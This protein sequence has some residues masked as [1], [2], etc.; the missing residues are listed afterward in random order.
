MTTIESAPSPIF[1]TGLSPFLKWP[2]G[3]SGELAKI[4][5][6][7]PSNASRFIEPFL[8]GG[9]VLLSVVDDIPAFGNDVVPELVGLYQGGA[10]NSQTLRNQLEILVECWRNFNDLES[11]YLRLAAQVVG[12]SWTSLSI[13]DL[14]PVVLNAVRIQDASVSH[15][16]ERRVHRDLPS[17]LARILKLQIQHDRE[18]PIDELANNI[19]ASIRSSY[20]M[21]IRARY[22]AAR[23]SNLWNETRTADFFFLREY[24]YASMFRFNSRDEFNIPYGGISY[25]RKNFKVKVDALFSTQMQARLSNSRFSVGD[26][27][28]LFEDSN[29]KSGDFIFVDPPY[30]SDFTDYD[31]RT[32]DSSDQQ[33][34]ASS[35]SSL[36]ANV[37]VVIGDT[38]L[39]RKLYP[40]TNWNIQSDDMFYKWTVKSRNERSAKHLTITNY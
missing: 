18:L 2:G 30:D 39:I 16:F 19:E 15:D 27:E 37:M 36:N 34:L 21:A 1:R 5:L 8:G 20:Y 7:S 23:V 22:N 4:A 26:F 6:A 31:G 38:P 40:D 29:P 14:L 25:N 35:L 9:S 10:S 3:K 28:T 17:K 33:R 11:L 32:F 24:C 13:S 12:S